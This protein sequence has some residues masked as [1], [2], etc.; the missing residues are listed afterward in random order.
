MSELYARMAGIV[1]MQITENRDGI[2]V[3][4]RDA[5]EQHYI[6][7]LPTGLLG[8]LIVHLQLAS[9]ELAPEQASSK[10]VGQPLGIMSG[11]PFLAAGL[12]SSTELIDQRSTQTCTLAGRVA[13][14]SAGALFALSRSYARRPPASSLQ[15]QTHLA[16]FALQ[17]RSRCPS[18]RSSAGMHAKS[19]AL[20]SPVSHSHSRNLC[21]APKEQL[22]WYRVHS[23][24]G[25]AAALGRYVPNA[26]RPARKPSRTPG[27]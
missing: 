17:T 27:P 24:A 18:P 9:Q 4:F 8:N 22:K 16:H 19:A 12:W 7:E 11:R 25:A 5:K 21:S 23:P 1:A 14:A 13:S 26:R 2:Q 15:R 20:L 10:G 3:R 6:V